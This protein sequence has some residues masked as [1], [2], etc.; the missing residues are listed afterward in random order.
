MEL[1]QRFARRP[2][3]SEWI[4][5]L[6]QR[7]WNTGAPQDRAKGSNNLAAKHFPA[8]QEKSSKISTWSKLFGTSKIV[9]EPGRRS[10]HIYAMEFERRL[11]RDQGGAGNRCRM[12]GHHQAQ[13][14][15]RYANRSVDG[16]LS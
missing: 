12:H 2:W 11:D 15:E 7:S 16:R 3:P 8:L 1:L 4:N 9:M 13:R 6:K 10:G 14:D 5:S